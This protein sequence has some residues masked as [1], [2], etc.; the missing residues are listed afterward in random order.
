[1][2]KII[3]LAFLYIITSCNYNLYETKPIVDYINARVISKTNDYNVYAVSNTNETV[4]MNIIT[5][6]N[7]MKINQDISGFFIRKSTTL[8]VDSNCRLK[9]IP[10]YIPEYDYNL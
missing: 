10:V 7:P 8:Y 5:K 9:T 3:I 4:F 2:K 6:S 1:M